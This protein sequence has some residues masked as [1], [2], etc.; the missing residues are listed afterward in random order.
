MALEGLFVEA[1]G[2]ERARGGDRGGCVV[3]P[4]APVEDRLG[5][6]PVEQAGIKMPQPK[7]AASRLPRVPLPEAAG[8]RGR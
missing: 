2:V 1:R 7:W 3:E 5:D 8:R 6:R 4:T